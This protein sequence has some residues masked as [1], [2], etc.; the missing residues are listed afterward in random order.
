MHVIDAIMRR[1][2][3]SKEKLLLQENTGLLKASRIITH[4]MLTPSSSAAWRPQTWCWNRCGF[5][6]S[7]KS[8][9]HSAKFSDGLHIKI[10]YLCLDYLSRFLCWSLAA[11][12]EKM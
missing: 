8:G 2:F 4:A 7:V 12:V 10:A 9:L 3:E 6:F 5:W 11:E 1:G